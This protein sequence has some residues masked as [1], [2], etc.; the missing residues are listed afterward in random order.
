MKKQKQLCVL[1][2][3]ESC[4]HIMNEKGV[5]PD[6]CD[7]SC[8]SLNNKCSHSTS[9][10]CLLCGQQLPEDSYIPSQSKD[11]QLL[12]SA[13]NNKNLKVICFTAP[14]IRVSL[15]DEFDMPAGNLIEGKM[16]TALKKL[17]FDKVFDMNSSADFTIVEEANEF[18]KRLKENKNL[19]MF[20]SCC[21]GWVNYCLKV[22]PEYRKNLSTCKSPQQM[23][24]ALINNY[25]AENQNIKS[26]DMFVVSI[27]PCLAKKL[28]LKQNNINT[29]VG[30]DVDVAITTKEIASLIK[31]NNIDFKSLDNSTYDD[32]F[33]SAS[34]AGA[35]FGNTGGVMEAVLRTLG[36][37][38]SGSEQKQLEYN[39]VRGL[40]GI[41]TATITINNQD[42][43]LAV[44]TGLKNVKNILDELKEDPKKYHFI[45]IMAC[46]GGCIGGGGQPCPANLT[47]QELLQAR[48]EGLYQAELKHTH[49]KAH[50]NPAVLKVYDEYLGAVGGKKAKKL[51]HR[52]YK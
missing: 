41:K 20:T 10:V 26:T 38:L 29:N 21:P 51:L 48:A 25:Y 2:Y 37:S 39:I 49:R 7:L 33:G 9:S 4:R 5:F 35:I 40:N 30:F 23:F 45:E 12:K 28:E 34:G 11:L 46:E 27:V 1:N 31:E 14:S 3:C 17:G 19:P 22:C 47:H 50:K 18:A 15:G 52:N 44:V 16:V 6:E 8:L 24:G 36:D 42:I 43:N 13:L 32:F